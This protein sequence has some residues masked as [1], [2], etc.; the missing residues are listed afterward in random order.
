MLW[1]TSR[2]GKRTKVAVLSGLLPAF[3]SLTPALVLLDE[4][5]AGLDDPSV[6]VLCDWM[7]EL[8]SKGHALLIATHDRRVMNRATHLDRY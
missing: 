1:R 6:E 4:P 2:R 8:R 5:D 3:A 7:E